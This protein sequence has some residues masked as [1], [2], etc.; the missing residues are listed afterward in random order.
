[1]R[2]TVW[3]LLIALLLQLAGS[4]WAWRGPQASGASEEHAA[5]CHGSA[6]AQAGVSDT[7]HAPK[8]PAAAGLQA[9]SH[10]CCAI[11]LGSHVQ[12]QV[13]PLPQATPA[14]RHGPWA[15]QSLQPDLRP[16]I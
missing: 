8:A 13:L 5:H 12:P 15:S 10:H 4:A 9:D 1:M 14:S 16:P 7:H 11:G 2:R 6:A 3:P